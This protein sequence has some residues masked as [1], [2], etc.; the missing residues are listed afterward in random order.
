M[1]RIRNI[2]IIIII[3]LAIYFLLNQIFLTRFNNLYTYIINPVSF[4]LIAL[5]LKQFIIPPYSTNKFKKDLSQYVLI[6]LLIYN[7]IYLLLG[8]VTGFGK[9]PYNTT[10]RG[11]VLNLIS[12]A[13]VFCCIEYIRYKLVK[14]VSRNDIKPI[15]VLIVIVFSLWEISIVKLFSYINS[16][17]TLFKEMFYTVIPIIV[18]NI[19]FTFLALKSDYG[20]AMLYQ[21]LY[22][23]VL[24]VSPI[25]PNIPWVLESMF[26]VLCPLILLLYAMYYISKK[27]RFHLNQIQNETNPFGFIPFSFALVTLICF[28]LGFFPIKPIGIATA[29]MYPTIKIGDAVIIKK[30]TANDVEPNDIIEYQMEGFTVVHRVVSKYQE[31]GETFFITKGDNNDDEDS[32]PVSEQQLIGKSIFKI[33]YIALPSVWLNAVDSQ[34]VREAR[35]RNRKVMVK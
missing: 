10:P 8:L 19:L 14:N 6:A 34:K 33:P 22:Y 17:Y 31:D 20:P 16:P 13:S 2:T 30:C 32:K 35:N 27:D 29:S 23:I 28:A 26:E 25:L 5:I 4:L 1:R 7:I 15:F 18:K 21:F 9:N 24:W 11:V 3:V 12:T